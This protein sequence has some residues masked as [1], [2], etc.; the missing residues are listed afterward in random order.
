MSVVTDLKEIDLFHQAFRESKIDPESADIHTVSRGFYNDLLITSDANQLR[1]AYYETK[2]GFI[3]TVFY[4][5]YEILKK[6]NLPV[7]A[8]IPTFEDIHYAVHKLILAYQLKLSRNNHI[9][10]IYIKINPSNMWYTK[11]NSYHTALE[12]MKVTRHIYEMTE[13]LSGT[14]LELPSKEYILFIPDTMIEQETEN[15]THFDLIK[16]I[17]KETTLTISMG[18]GFGTCLDEAKN[19]AEQ[20][21][22]QSYKTGGSRVFVRGSQD[23]VVMPILYDSAEA[24][25]LSDDNF[26]DLS[27]KT[28]ISMHILSSLYLIC[29][30]QSRNQ[31]T[32]E[33]LCDAIGITRRVMN[34]ALLKLMDHGLCYE[35]G[36]YFSH[37]HGRP[38]RILEI[39]LKED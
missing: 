30:E 33:E 26:A 17:Q 23:T 20:A 3:A 22:L 18:I 2:A 29:Q 32:S 12:Q 14:C 35:T 9:A 27:K 21:M 6:E 5:V 16:K 28:G 39:H 11:G 24:L 38:S 25:P 8:L 19:N 13:K 31:F 34:R 1:S 7:F 36:R 37:P 4:K 10:S 15:F